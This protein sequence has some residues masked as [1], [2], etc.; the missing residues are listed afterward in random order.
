MKYESW[1]GAAAGL[2]LF[3]LAACSDQTGEA[4]S[5]GGMPGMGGPVE[6]GVVTLSSQAVPRTTV[7]PG[8]V[9]A[10]ATAE[11]RPEVDG[12]IKELTFKEGASVAVGDALYV[13]DSV[14][15]QAVYNAAAAAVRKAQAE[16]ESAQAAYD[17]ASR[18]AE[19]ETVSKE[20]LEEAR[21]AL[22]TAKADVEVAEA[23]R[24]AAQINLD[25][26][27]IRAPIAGV[28]GKSAVSIGALVTANQTDGLAIIRQID[29]IY[30]DLVD[31]SAN[32]LRIR[33]QVQAGL[34][35]GNG[36]PP[37]VHL[38]LEDGTA[39]EPAGTIS[40]TEVAVSESTGT[41]LLRATFDNPHQILLPGMFVRATVDLGTTPGAFLVPQR[42]VMRD[43]NGEA[44]AYFVSADGK[45][46]SRVLTTSISIGND[47][48]VTGRVAD[49]DRVIVD[50]LQKIS[51]GTAVTPVEVTIDDDGVVRQEL[52]GT[53]AGDAAEGGAE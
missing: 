23:D 12:I 45:A 50:G 53:A 8:R 46:E 13:I 6:V 40:L 51:D 11:I 7:L 19:S 25:K 26:T 35:G 47:W 44:T 31:S 16:A 49:G 21:T 20:T 42:A 28:I 17:R 41:F 3:A 10:Y 30:V 24:Q 32:L 4:P 48:L 52:G 15:Y 29:P 33:N 36:G 38:T 18:L 43:A 34:L 37:V 14:R 22:E 5:G 1:A 39:Y 27:T 9:T 2:C